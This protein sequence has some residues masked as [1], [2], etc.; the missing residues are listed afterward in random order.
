MKKLLFVLAIAST[1]NGPLAQAE[2]TNMPRPLLDM[3]WL[4]DDSPDPLEAM[5]RK[6]VAEAE[7]EFQNKNDLGALPVN[8]LNYYRAMV[9]NAC[10]K[11]DVGIAS[12]ER[13]MVLFIARQELKHS[14]SGSI[15]IL[16]TSTP[17]S[18]MDTR[19]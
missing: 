11:S 13:D 7:V 8:R 10:Y 1:L 19:E 4:V 6:C 16:E 14:F 18:V 17:S 2:E 12:Y 15:S 3:L 9:F 5:I